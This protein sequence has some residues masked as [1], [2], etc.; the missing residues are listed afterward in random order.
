MFQLRPALAAQIQPP[1][2]ENAR[3][4]GGPV[5]LCLHTSNARCLG[6]TA[7][8]TYSFPHLS[9]P[10]SLFLSLFLSLSLLDGGR[11][12]RR[13]RTEKAERERPFSTGSNT[14][15]GLFN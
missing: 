1:H 10:L 2:R 5:H 11:G 14:A 9:L 8:F 13:R 4:P 3:C 7:G 6:Y 15:N 12:Q